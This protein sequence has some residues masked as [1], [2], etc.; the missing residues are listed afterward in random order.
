VVP[1]ND[2]DAGFVREHQIARGHIDVA[3]PNRLAGGTLLKP[4]AGC[5]GNPALGEDGEAAFAGFVHVPAGA[6]RDDPPDAVQSGTKAEEASP[7]GNVGAPVIGNNDHV[8]AGGCCHGSGT[9]VGSRWSRNVGLKLDG[10]GEPHDLGVA[11]N[12]KE[13]CLSRR[14][15]EGVEGVRHGCGI[16]L[17]VCGQEGCFCG[18]HA[19]SRAQ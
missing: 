10:D 17:L 16:E 12:R 13:A 19:S 11:P 8:R 9:N 1:G 4:A 14:Q 6:V 18:G 5:G 15:P 2:D 7:A 3:E